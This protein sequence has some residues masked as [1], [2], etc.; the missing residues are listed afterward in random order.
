MQS[1]L[2]AVVYYAEADEL[3][4]YFLQANTVMVFALVLAAFT[5]DMSIGVSAFNG[6][7]ANL[8]FAI[9]AYSVLSQVIVQ[10]TKGLSVTPRRK[11]KAVLSISGIILL[12]IF[13][14]MIAAVVLQVEQFGWKTVWTSP[15]V[16]LWEKNCDI[17]I[18][19]TQPI[20]DRFGQAVKMTF[21]GIMLVISWIDIYGA[22][23]SF[24]NARKT[25]PDRPLDHLK[26]FRRPLRRV[27]DLILYLGCLG[28]LVAVIEH[29]VHTSPFNALSDAGYW[30]F[31]Q[32]MAIAMTASHFLE[33]A[34][35]LD[36]PS[37]SEPNLS[38]LE[39]LWPC[40]KR[41]ILSRPEPDFRRQPRPSPT[42]EILDK[43]NIVLDKTKITLD[44]GSFVF[45]VLQRMFIGNIHVS[46]ELDFID[47]FIIIT[48]SKS[49]DWKNDQLPFDNF[50]EFTAIAEDFTSRNLREQEDPT[51]PRSLRSRVLAD[52]RAGKS[53][54]AIKRRKPQLPPQALLSRSSGVTSL[55]VGDMSARP[56]PAPG[57]LGQPA[58]R[59]RKI[60]SVPT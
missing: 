48:T 49:P 43:F 7:I 20:L 12:S 37:E 8:L 25:G 36:G 58:L 1:F 24:K 27:A 21:G 22:W 57:N 51:L 9:L 4:L 55:T 44:L 34:S 11:H 16:K 41:W 39:V 15:P 17:G 45:R 54:T 33:I 60:S 47:R 29:T 14:P 19:L 10:G 56:V 40:L 23:N 13:P 6:E 18:D 35:Y 32:I 52:I 53:N 59:A 26:S 2:S 31:G 3:V 38:K 30:A 42:T 28:F 50:R 5:A 46:R